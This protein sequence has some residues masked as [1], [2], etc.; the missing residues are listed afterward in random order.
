MT[1]GAWSW[2]KST[3]YGNKELFS[4]ETKKHIDMDRMIILQSGREIAEQ[5]IEDNKDKP[6]DHLILFG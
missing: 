6:R 5:L 2:Q 1:I 4:A 3:P